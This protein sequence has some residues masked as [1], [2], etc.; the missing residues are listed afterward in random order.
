MMVDSDV[1]G[2]WVKSLISM[3]TTKLLLVLRFKSLLP[4]DFFTHSGFM[5]KVAKLSLRGFFMSSGGSTTNK[6]VNYFFVTVLLVSLPLGI[7]WAIQHKKTPFKINLLDKNASLEPEIG[8][9][10]HIG[11]GPRVFPGNDRQSVNVNPTP[12]AHFFD[13]TGFDNATT[14]GLLLGTDFPA[15]QETTE[16]TPS[17]HTLANLIIRP[18]LNQQ[19]RPCQPRRNQGLSL[20]GR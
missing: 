10:Q 6:F 2:K 4:L 13:I 9:N 11:S 5:E 7:Y 17:S 14:T 1:R 3:K 18:L 20:A 8:D 12:K 19:M 16:D 15:Y